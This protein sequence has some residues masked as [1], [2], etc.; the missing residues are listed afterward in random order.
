MAEKKPKPP[1]KPCP[2]CE[3]AGHFDNAPIESYQKCLVS[4]KKGE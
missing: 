2:A 3:G 1:K 4:Q